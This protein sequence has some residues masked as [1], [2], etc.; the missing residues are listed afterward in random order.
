M[1]FAV[2]SHKSW[3][4]RDTG[5]E[6]VV[7]IDRRKHGMEWYKGVYES[8]K[9]INMKL[10]SSRLIRLGCRHGWGILIYLK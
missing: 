4:L 3:G 2:G 5:H 7:E 1:K 10:G 6:V 8:K 9:N